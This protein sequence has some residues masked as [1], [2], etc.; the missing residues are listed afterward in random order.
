MLQILRR[1]ILV[2]IFVIPCGCAS[3]DFDYPRSESSAFTDTADTRFGRVFADAVS[4][5]PGK[6][7]FLPLED[8]VDAL[9]MRLVLAERAERSIDAQYDP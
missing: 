6:A 7:G 1:T 3:I 5:H 2:A 9:A 4:A 8:G